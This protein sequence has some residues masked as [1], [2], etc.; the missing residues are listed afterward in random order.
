VLTR[1]VMTGG[2]TARV[3]YE[4]EITPVSIWMARAAMSNFRTLHRERKAVTVTVYWASGHGGH[5]YQRIELI[6]RGEQR[7]GHRDSGMVRWQW[8][9]VGVWGSAPRFT[10]K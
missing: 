6:K 8:K 4:R 9:C 3:K 7:G 2:M 5:P 1:G 10:T